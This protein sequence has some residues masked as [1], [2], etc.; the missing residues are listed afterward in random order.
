MAFDRGSVRSFDQDGRLHVEIT[1]ISK[2]NVCPYRGDEI[3][4]HEK[5]GLEPNRIYMLLR[6]PAELEKGASTANNL[7]VLNAHIPVSAVDHKPENVVGA[8][9]SDAVFNAPYLDNSMVIWVQDSIQKIEDGS[10]QELSSA[11]YYDADMTPGTYEGEHYDGVMRNIRFNHV[12][13]V[14]KGRAGPDVMVGDSSL[15]NTGALNMSK[16][17]LSKKAVLAK[18]AMLAVLRPKMAADAKLDLDKMLA[19]VTNKNWAEK[20]PA[21]VAAIKPLLAKDADLADVVELLD[22]LDGEQPDDDNVAQDEPDPKCAEILNMLRGKISD[23]DL[24]QIEAKMSAPAAGAVK[25]QAT[26]EPV[27]T[28]GAANAN[29]KDD[30]NKKPIPGANDDDDGVSQ[31]AMDKAIKLAVD[32]ARADTKAQT[33]A[34]FRGIQEAEDLVKPYVGKLAVA[35]DSA[36]AVYKT[37]LEMLKVDIKGVH[38]SAFKAILT[39]QPKPGAEVKPRIAQDS[40]AS[41]SAD[42]LEAFPDA[43]RISR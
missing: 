3:P 33:L 36:E 14:P 6:D 37:A 2:A 1:H 11:Y 19:G 20:K 10:E 16:Q 25:P 40:G 34:L 39:A 7:P 22:K 18:G 4:D 26:D 23:E 31:A 9:G 30:E 43:N 28:P 15:E 21:L 27:Q 35:M 29:P 41:V 24:A 32:A 8:T 42:F 5:L 12:A 17:S 38:P 13:L